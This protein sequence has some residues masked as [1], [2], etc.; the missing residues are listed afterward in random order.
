MLRFGRIYFLTL[1]AGMFLFQSVAS[2]QVSVG[3]L[4]PQ[5]NSLVMQ[6]STVN[7]MGTA[8]ASLNFLDYIKI[9]QGGTTLAQRTYTMY[10]FIYSDTLA[11]TYT[12]PTNATP[13]SQIT[14]TIESA[15]KNEMYYYRA[16]VTVIVGAA[17]TTPPTYSG[18]A[19]IKSAIRG[20]GNTSATIQW[21]QATDNV[22]TAANM[23]YEIYYDTV[24]ANVF[25]AGVKQTVTGVLTTD[26]TGL[27]PLSNYYVGVRAVDESNNR[28]TNTNTL[29]VSRINAVPAQSWSLYE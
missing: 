16:Y 21:Y 27:A 11:A 9:S 28:E 13:G 4:L 2:A 7:I 15:A 29:L 12:V 17:D 23:K 3:F 24:Q 14:F 18:T 10:E 26:I 6:G 25:T 19:G 8:M 22:T 20:A 1:I 5:N